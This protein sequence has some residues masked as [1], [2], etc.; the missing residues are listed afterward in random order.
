MFKEHVALSQQQQLVTG[1]RQ[2]RCTMPHNLFAGIQLNARSNFSSHQQFHKKD[3]GVTGAW[4]GS[5][6]DPDT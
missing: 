5:D 1:K 6:S 4:G 3:L 2:L